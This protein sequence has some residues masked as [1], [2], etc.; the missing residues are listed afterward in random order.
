MT[1]FL[2][3]VEL[4]NLFCVVLLGALAVTSLFTTNTDN[5]LAMNIATGLIGYLSKGVLKK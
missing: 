3:T 5:T 2:K 1:D 4:D